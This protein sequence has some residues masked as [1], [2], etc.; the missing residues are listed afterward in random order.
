MSIGTTG[1]IIAA[2]AIGAGGSLLGAGLQSSAAQGAAGT[3]AQSSEFAAQLQAEMAQEALQFQEQEYANTLGLEEPN[4]LTG[5]NAESTLDQLMGLPGVS[6]NMSI[7]QNPL[8]GLSSNA[9]PT[10]IPIPGGGNLPLGSLGA[11]GPLGNAPI[12]QQQFMPQ[13]ATTSVPSGNQNLPLSTLAASAQA[14]GLTPPFAQ[15]QSASL[16]IP[17]FPGQQTGSTPVGSPL[18]ALSTS[19]NP[20]FGGNP[21]SVG[22]VSHHTPPTTISANGNPA[23]L[24]VPSTT[25]T[26]GSTG[27]PLGFLSQTWNT[28]FVPPTA[29]QAA[30]TPGEQ[31]ELQQGLQALNN[32]AAAKGTLLTGGTGKAEQEFGQGLAS[33][34]YQQAYNNALTN[35]QTAY[36]VFNNNQTNLFNRLATLAGYGQTS[37]NQLS[38]TG[39]NA[40]NSFSNTL[41]GA[42]SQ[43]GGDVQSA[44]AALASGQVGSANAFAGGLSGLSSFASLLPFLLNSSNSGLGLGNAN[45]GNI[46][47]CWIAEELYGKDDVRTHLVRKW[48]KEEFSKSAFGA[49]LVALYRKYGQRIARVIHRVPMLKRAV[50]PL[51]DSAVRQ[52]TAFYAQ[53][54]RVAAHDWIHDP[55]PETNPMF[56]M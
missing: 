37:A 4:Y 17:I 47:F 8:G 35:Y 56:Q 12:A 22:P 39:A 19:P 21:G 53:Q 49:F 30:Q 10:N 31:F 18:G 1:A 6:P 7:F 43:I 34:N 33:T 50:R 25:G 11:Q 46:G 14:E 24:T 51:F 44:A 36:N 3:Q 20:R 26:V 42:G 40:A 48:L 54:L 32:S 28:P 16:A 13:S 38:A 9:I 23:Q 55:D 52:A 27:L 45:P 5:I 15:P 41:L 29:E 2:G